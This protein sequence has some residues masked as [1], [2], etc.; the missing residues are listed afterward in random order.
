MVKAHIWCIIVMVMISS[1]IA[2]ETKDATRAAGEPVVLFEDPLD[3]R[4]VPGW[5]I[6]PGS[7][8]KAPDG[9]SAALFTC[10][11]IQP[12]KPVPMAG[13]ESW[14]NYRL[15]VEIMPARE[16]GF[17]G[18]DFN[19]RKSDGCSCNLHFATFGNTLSLQPMR[20]CGPGT[21]SWKLWPVSQRKIPFPKGQWIR[22]RIDAGETIANVYVND[23]AEPMCTIYDLPSPAGGVCFWA[24]YGGSGYYRN[25][26]V[27]QLSPGDVKP[28]L[29]DLWAGASRQNVPRD[30]R[31]TGLH[32][33]GFGRDGLPAE[34]LADK[35]EWKPIKTDRR[36]VVDIGAAFRQYDCNTVYVETVIQSNQDVVRSAWVTYTDRFTLY[37]N[38]KEAFKGPDRHWFSPD[39]EKYGSSRLIP[40]QFEVRLPLKVGEN[41][42]LIRSEAIERFGWGFWMRLD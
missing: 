24:S 15:T 3:G 28:L 13:G 11:G 35:V 38:G 21:E 16:Q 32:P 10:E 6:P 12:D 33:A 37:C 23:D 36:G 14:R 26:R 5:I 25:L 19:V 8:A 17:L 29:A 42:L 34:I 1:A 30:W 7:F 27:T 22:L 18:I 9:N 39:R 31:V 20:Y 2:V 41:K 4:S 40:D